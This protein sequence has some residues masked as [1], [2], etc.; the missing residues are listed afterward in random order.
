[1][2]NPASGICRA[3]LGA[4]LL[5][6][7][8]VALAWD[9]DTAIT[10]AMERDE[11]LR[12]LEQRRS[13][14]S[15]RAVADG[16][17]PDPEVMVG[18]EGVPVSDPFDADM[19][20]M[21][22]IGVRQRFPA[23]QTR[24]LTRQRTGQ[25][26]DTLAA[27]ISARRLDIARETR[28]AWL[29]WASAW[30]SLEIAEQA[31]E[32]FEELEEITKARYRA[33]T[34]RQRDVDQARMELALLERRILVKRTGV[35]EAA[36]RLARWTGGHPDVAPEDSLE[37]LEKPEALAHLQRRLANHPILLAG[38]HR[39][40]AG[41]TE[42]R[43][44]HQAYRP[45]WMVEAGYAHTRGMNPMTMSRQS[46]KLFAMVSFSVPLFTADRQDRRLSAARSDL[47]AVNHERGLE[48]QRFKGELSR[49]HSL[50]QSQ[51]QQLEW[52]QSRV[53]TSAEATV[54]ST[55]SAYRADRASFDELVRA[56]LALLDQQLETI[57]IR[58]ARTAATIELAWLTA[59]TLP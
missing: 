57:N 4:S 42:T 49:Q 33:G 55:L 19:M 50:W 9:A 46:D 40:E 36:S 54:E 13:A 16:S 30:R 18:V 51:D 32:A 14:L 35:D 11:G 28:T 20:T 45:S 56:R 52:M 37:L 7:S 5:W 27:E 59:E 25:E 23:G 41:I 3:L 39:V 29:D 58:Q 8:H 34:G 10:L 1:M 38:D 2:R 21:Y 6:L 17:L 24:E 44:A 22:K 53:L 43:L 12:A 31:A 26:A 47:R 48:L 15:E